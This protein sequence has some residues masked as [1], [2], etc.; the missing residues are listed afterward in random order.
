MFWTFWDGG[1]KTGRPLQFHE[2]EKPGQ[3]ARL[4]WRLGCLEYPESSLRGSAL[5]WRQFKDCP[6]VE[7]AALL[8][9]SIRIAAR[10]IEAQL[11][12]PELKRLE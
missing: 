12:M 8:R 11:R 9:R 1:G 4:L 5:W 7:L 10:V 3:P 2:E 6:P